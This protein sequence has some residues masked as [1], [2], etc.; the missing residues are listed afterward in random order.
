LFDNSNII[1]A[2]A[3]LKSQVAGEFKGIFNSKINKLVDQ[4]ACS[5]ESVR[6]LGHSIKRE[7]N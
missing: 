1:K 7:I 3:S 2:I 4:I 6:G 5:S